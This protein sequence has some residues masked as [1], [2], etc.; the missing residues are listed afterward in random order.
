[1]IALNRSTSF[2]VGAFAIIVISGAVGFGFWLGRSDPPP[3]KTSDRPVLYWYDPMVPAQHFERPGK[4]PFMDMQL[5]PK[6]ADDAGGATGVAIDPAKIQNLGIRYATVTRTSMGE[7]IIAPGVIDFNQRDVAVVQARSG[8]FVQRVYG[9][10]PGDII[11]AGALLADVLLPEWASA[12]TEYLAVRRTGNETLTAASR[13][14]LALLGMPATL[15]EEVERSGQ[16]KAITTISTPSG[17]VIRTL[18]VRAG[19]TVTAG[20]TLAEVNGIRTVWV[21]ASVPSAAAALLRP[22][23]SAQVTPAGDARPVSGR[24]TAILPEVQGET[25]TV[26]VRIELA[27]PNGSLRPGG[28]VNVGFSGSSKAAL[29]IPSEAVIR[30]GRRT[31][32]M[33]ALANGRFQPAEVQTGTEAG[34]RTEILSGLSEGERIVASGQFLIDSEASLSGMQARP[35]AAAAAAAT[36]TRPQPQMLI[37]SLGRIEKVDPMSVTLSHPPI[38]ALQWP[39]M[40]MAFRL[41]DPAM[42]RGLKV[43]DRV[44]FAFD[45]PK[46]GPTIRRIGKD[47]AR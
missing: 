6:Y 37:E 36:T 5:V 19:M 9:R 44:Q 3:A 26:Q 20:Q 7:A 45:Q 13:Q 31:L 41:P 18:T 40:T 27:N 14:R 12:Q 23:Q 32:V 42:A 30:T 16:V 33:L 10:A 28:F 25:R 15:I 8:G 29:T 43:G 11:P 39:A 24:L 47:S 35:A 46:D 21:N 34:D 17:G 38:P 22:G 4:S 2:A 1:M